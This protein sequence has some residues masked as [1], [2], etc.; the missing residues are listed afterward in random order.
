[1]RKK[2]YGNELIRKLFEDYGKE[3]SPK[4]IFSLIEKAGLS[5]PV[6]TFRA[7]IDKYPGFLTYP[8]FLDIVNKT[9]SPKEIVDL[10]FKQKPHTIKKRRTKGEKKMKL[11]NWEVFKVAWDMLNPKSTDYLGDDLISLIAF[12]SH[13]L[14]PYRS[15][16]LPAMPSKEDFLPA[17]ILCALGISSNQ[18]DKDMKLRKWVDDMNLRVDHE[19]WFLKKVL[20]VMTPWVLKQYPDATLWF[21]DI[22]GDAAWYYGHP[23]KRKSSN[24]PKYEK[25]YDLFIRQLEGETRSQ[26][27]YTRNTYHNFIKSRRPQGALMFLREIHDLL[28]GLTERAQENIHNKKLEIKDSCKD[29]K[30]FEYRELL[31]QLYREEF[32]K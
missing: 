24:R 28:Y 19:I 6:R 12:K 18:Y 10:I 30:K 21:S 22:F 8:Q 4:S 31:R 32:S 20:S 23:R 5:K 27:G 2:E 15:P 14:E 13:L 11:P 3:P 17:Y 25:S 16:V 1:M 9:D 29:L 7:I 26:L